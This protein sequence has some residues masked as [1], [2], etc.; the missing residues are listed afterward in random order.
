[1]P[2]PPIPTQSHHV[3]GWFWKTGAWSC[4]QGIPSPSF[5]KATWADPSL[6]SVLRTQN[7]IRLLVCQSLTRRAGERR[8]N[9]RIGRI[10]VAFGGSWVYQR[11]E[12]PLLFQIRCHSWEQCAEPI[13]LTERPRIVCKEP[14]SSHCYRQIEQTDSLHGFL[15]SP[16]S[17]WNLLA[18]GEYRLSPESLWL[19]V[20]GFFF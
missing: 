11:K 17:S 3:P 10:F 7:P 15:F 2:N 5:S 1:M 13:R 16:Q 19:P 6:P 4:P 14:I 9:K 18:G 20:H 8:R 12:V